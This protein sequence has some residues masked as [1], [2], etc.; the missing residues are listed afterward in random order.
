MIFLTHWGYVVITLAVT[1]DACLVTHRIVKQRS[2]VF[3][4]RK[5]AKPE[6]CDWILK[7]SI[8]LTAMAYPMALFVT[9]MYWSFLFDF[10]AHFVLD[11]WSYLNLIVHLMQVVTE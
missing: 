7:L 10:S 3:M 5:H 8:F 1:F 11:K 4:K 6:E 2:K 9:L